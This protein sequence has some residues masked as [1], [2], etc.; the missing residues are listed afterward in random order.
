FHVQSS[1]EKEVSA[2]NVLVAVFSE[3]DSHAV[4]LLNHQNITRLD[5]VN[6][7]S[8]GITREV[9]EEDEAE[10]AAAEEAQTEGKKKPEA[11]PLEQFATNLNRQARQG[12]IDPLVGREVELARTMQILCRRR[13]NNPLYVGE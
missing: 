9:D 2:L 4:Y 13:K 6:Y 3:K 10:E 5:V 11:S 7:I 1:G 12:R 8:H